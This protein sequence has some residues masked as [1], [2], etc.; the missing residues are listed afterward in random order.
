MQIILKDETLELK[1]RRLFKEDKFAGFVIWYE[2]DGKNI[3]NIKLKANIARADIKGYGNVFRYV[4]T[5]E[6]ATEILYELIKDPEEYQYSV[7]STIFTEF[8][9]QEN[10]FIPNNEAAQKCLLLKTHKNSE[11]SESKSSSN[12]T[13]KNIPLLECFQW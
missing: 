8:K 11:R 13:E 12:T 2:Q 3:A 1:G 4:F 7:F 9:H 5:K 10:S 6:I